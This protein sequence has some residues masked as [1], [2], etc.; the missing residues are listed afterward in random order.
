MKILLSML[1]VIA[2]STAAYA[3][4][5]T[6]TWKA[7]FDTQR[8]VQK[9]TITLKQDGA[10][11]TGTASVETADQKRDVEFKDVK[12]DGDTVTFVETLNAQGNDLRIVYTGKISG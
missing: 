4:D 6:G 12:L 5:V 10:S 11:V 3:A 9:Y 7:E 8:G 1:A 2:I